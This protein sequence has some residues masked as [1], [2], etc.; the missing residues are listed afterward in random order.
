MIRKLLLALTTLFLIALPFLVGTSISKYTPYVETNSFLTYVT[1]WTVI[2]IAFASISVLAIRYFYKEFEPL[3]ISGMLL[4]FMASPI[5][6]IVGLA[7]AP[8]LSIKMLEHP[9]REH[10][11]YLFLFL[12]LLLF[13]AFFFL[14]FKNN[15]LKITGSKK[16][17]I[18]GL[19]LLAFAEFGWEFTHHYLYPEGLQAWINQGKNVE[20]FGKNYDDSNAINLGVFGRFMQFSLIF[21]L[22]IQLYKLRKISIWSPILTTVFS[23]LGI[24]S[25]TVIFI[26]E[27]NIPKGYEILFLFF[28]PGIPFLVL[29]W[30]GVALLTG[31]R[32]SEI[33]GLK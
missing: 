1:L 25:A 20:E 5:I 33:E 9:E 17:I 6:G 3:L 19:F 18:T 23:L 32:S 24:V 2:T 8:D 29:Y 14:M 7:A 12:A 26:T 13:G 21:W 11:R 15:S 16:W 22:A 28:I 31:Y 10:L 27:M 30:L 4:L